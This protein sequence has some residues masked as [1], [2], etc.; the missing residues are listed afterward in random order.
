MEGLVRFEMLQSQKQES[1]F[2]PRAPEERI[3]QA[4]TGKEQRA[5]V[6]DAAVGKGQ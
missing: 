1:G 2:S 3:P 5:E 6:R 4:G